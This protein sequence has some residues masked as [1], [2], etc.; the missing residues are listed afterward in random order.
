[1]AMLRPGASV[2][3]KMRLT[4]LIQQIRAFHAARNLT[5]YVAGANDSSG[6]P[7]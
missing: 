6:Y 3:A 4:A 2:A 7:A 1:M 5:A